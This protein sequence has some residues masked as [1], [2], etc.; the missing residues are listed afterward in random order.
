MHNLLTDHGALNA[1]ARPVSVQDE[2]KTLFLA[3]REEPYRVRAE[4]RRFLERSLLATR[5]QPCDLPA[6]PAGLDAWC[7]QHTVRVG[8]AY[9]DYLAERKGGAPRRYF[10]NQAGALYFLRGAAPTKLVDGAWL[11]G[12]L[13]H[14]GDAAY[15]GLIRTYLEELGDGVED[16]NH[17][18]L[19][20]NLLARH[21]CD[22]WEDL[23]D[24]H[25]VQGAL[26]LALATHGADML[27]ELVG[28]NLGY[29][30]LPLHLLITA[31]ELNELGIDPYY[32]T[33]HVTVDNASNGHAKRAIDAVRQL[34]Q[35]ASD[36]AEFWR[37][38]VD[39]YRLNDL[40][41]ST[42][43]II[44]SFDLDAELERILVA[45]GAVG[46][47]LHSD[48]CKIEGRAISDWLTDAADMPELLAAFQRT[49]WIQRGH[50]AEESRFWGLVS[51]T[52]AQMFG[53]FSAYELQVLRDWIEY[54][55][56]QPGPRVASFRARQRVLES[57]MPERVASHA[58]RGLIRQQASD[59]PNGLRQFE[60]QV[61]QAGSKSAM[62]ELLI[63]QM[64]PARHHTLTGLMATRM[65]ARLLDA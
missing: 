61:A 8:Q 53:V 5:T 65:Y 58:P 43:S 17:V 33:L 1:P 25:F 26:Q 62:M 12:V 6:D 29:E 47:H 44:A 57:G 7:E 39:G 31:Y 4:A 41:A 11:Y 40:G 34:M 2:A 42:N 30:Q 24:E 36:P 60:L 3:M 32:F 49:G 56:G 37:R 19:Y 27:P 63:A 51:G 55:P 46:K 52:R 14:W 64:S 9:R 18:A 23:S 45:K 13:K 16:K 15:H 35:H 22:Q 54:S 10:P 20:Q 28:Y 48:Y 50:K 59:D 21:G 38:V